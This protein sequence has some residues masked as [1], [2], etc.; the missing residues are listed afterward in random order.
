M[1]SLSLHYGI[2]FGVIYEQ[3]E[4][5]VRGSGRAAGMA[6]GP[7]YRRQPCEGSARSQAEH[8]EPPSALREAEAGGAP[9]GAAGAAGVGRGRQ[10]RLR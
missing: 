8:F 9:A 5:G 7:Q 4:V 1:F 10:G 3:G 6:T 2:F